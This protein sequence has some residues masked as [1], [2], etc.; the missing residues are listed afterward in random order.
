MEQ[1]FDYSTYPNYPKEFKDLLDR[2]DEGKDS[3]IG[4]GNPS[5]KI[6]IIGKECSSEDDAF[7][8]NAELWKTKSPE[9]I[10]NWFDA[11]WNMEKYHP[12]QP[13]KGQLFLKDNK[14]EDINLS[15]RGTSSTWCAYQRFINELL[16]E[17]QQVQPR[18]QLNFYD[19][20]FITELST[21][22]MP[23]SANHW[24]SETAKSINARLLSDN[25][26]LRAEF[27]QQFPI[28]IL[29]CYHYKD[30]YNIDIEKCFNQKYKGPVKKYGKKH[31]FINI[32]ISEDNKPHLLLHTN[33][34]CMRSHVF[35]EAVGSVCNE[36]MREHDI[37]I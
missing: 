3:Y 27:F 20:C 34:F 12:R 25:G 5:S 11:R 8:K 14:K 1:V 26:I 33:H 6:L 9:N 22:N 21:N 4:Q 37:S 29:A 28:I 15:N 32:H 24:V 13:Y 2:K 35:I 19:Y 7:Y 10:E 23:H 30:I 31:E 16:P 18:Q 36:F 17:S